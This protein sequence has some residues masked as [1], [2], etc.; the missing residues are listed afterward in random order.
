MKLTQYRVAYPGSYVMERSK[1]K[2]LAN[3]VWQ[4]TYQSNQWVE[5]V[6]VDED[7]QNMTVTLVD[8]R[9]S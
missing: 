5:R 6:I 9:A 8:N 4:K 2:R 3:R 1:F 7:L